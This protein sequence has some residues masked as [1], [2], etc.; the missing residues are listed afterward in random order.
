MTIQNCD[1]NDIKEIF[2]LYQTARDFQVVKGVVVWPIFDK[3]LIENEIETF[4]QWKIVIDNE[5]ACVWATTFDDPL[6]WEELNNDSSI[7]IHR[8]AT[9]KNYRGLNFV[10]EIV[11]WSREYAKLHHKKY[12][13]L[14]T[15]AGNNS[16]IAYY[17]KSGFEYLGDKKLQET[18]GLP[19]HYHQATVSLF[20][21]KIS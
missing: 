12:I 15:I 1:S 2:N 20:E 7:Y 16:L 14:D 17:Q 10:Q 3:T 19:D 8:I 9:N 21:I 13:R 11:K 5:V 6:I 18:K 4:N